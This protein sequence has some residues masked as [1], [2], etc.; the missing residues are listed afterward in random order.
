VII[1]GYLPLLRRTQISGLN[2][3]GTGAL[4]KLL[5]H[6]GD[7]YL[8]IHYGSVRGILCFLRAYRWRRFL[9]LFFYSLGF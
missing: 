1:P 7:P 9:E 5:L 3:K 6:L 8:S 2:I 4:L